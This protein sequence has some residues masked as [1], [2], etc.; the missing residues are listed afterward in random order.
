M[1]VARRDEHVEVRPLGDADR[2]DGPLRVAV[3]AAGERRDR[4][5][6]RLAGDPL[7]GLEVAGRGG[8]EAGLDDVDLEPD[9]LAG[10]LEL[11][12]RGQP[13]AGRLLAVAQGRVEDPDAEPGGHRA[14]S[15]TR[16]GSLAAAWAW[17]AWTT[18]GSRNAIWPRSSAPTR[19]IRWS[20]SCCAQPLELGPAGVVL[21]DPARGERAVLDLRED[22]LHRRADVVVDDPRAADVV[23]ELGRVADAEAHEV[24]AAAVHQVDDELELVHRLE[25]GQLGLVAGLDERLEGHLDQ[26]RRPAAQDRLLAEQ[27]GLGLLGEGRLEDAGA[28]AAERPGVGQDAGAGRSRSRRA[29]RRTGRARRRRPGRRSGRGGRGPSG[30]TIPT[31]M[32]AGG[33]IRSKWMLKPWAN[34]SSWPGRRFGRDLG[35]VDRLLGGVRDEDHDRRRRP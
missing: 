12:G 25:V 32:P 34:I 8:R 14:D 7:D 33:S 22:L 16:R 13:G 27:V 9:E 30:A 10:D 5:A 17:P 11:L 21:G 6:L 31:S 28:G 20:W 35:V 23:A 18:T 3:A 15:A 2:L 1:D 19:S 4:H 24:E 26:R 29:G